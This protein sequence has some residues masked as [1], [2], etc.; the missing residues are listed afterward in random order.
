MDFDSG[1]L[2]GSNKTQTVELELEFD[3][4]ESDSEQDDTKLMTKKLSLW[5][6]K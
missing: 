6:P 3:S 5:T 2:N 4:S 1:N